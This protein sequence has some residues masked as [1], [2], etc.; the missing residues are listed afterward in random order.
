MAKPID[1]KR[2]TSLVAK[3]AARQKTCQGSD[4]PVT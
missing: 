1:R 3:Y 2:L 4:V